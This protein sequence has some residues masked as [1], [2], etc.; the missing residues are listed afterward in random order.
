M[1]KLV[2]TDDDKTVTERHAFWFGGKTYRVYEPSTGDSWLIE[3]TL[4][5]GGHNALARLMLKKPT[6]GITRY[7][8]PSDNNSYVNL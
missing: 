4:N 1:I 6:A 2:I 7:S 5:Q 8:L 3:H